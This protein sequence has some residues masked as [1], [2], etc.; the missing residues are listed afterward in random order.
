M[1]FNKKHEDNLCIVDASTAPHNPRTRTSMAIME[2]R[3]AP[4]CS[5]RLVFNILDWAECLSGLVLACSPL[6][7]TRVS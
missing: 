5:D 2:P 1:N 7:L 4:D 6:S 3:F